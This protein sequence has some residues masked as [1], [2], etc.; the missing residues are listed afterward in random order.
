MK[1]I[2]NYVGP[3]AMG[4][5]MGVITPGMDIVNEVFEI[6]KSVHRD[7]LLNDGDII[8]ITESVVARAQDNYI[9]VNEVSDIIREALDLPKN[10]T[11]GVVFP[12]TSRNR[13]SMILE[14]IA[15]AVPEGKVIVQFSYP[16]DEVGNQVISPEFV[17]GLEKDLITLEDIDDEECIHP[18]TGVNYIKYYE[19]IIEDAGAESEII[20]CNDPKQILQYEPDGVIAADI[21]TRKKT[22]KAIKKEIDKCITLDEVCTE[23]EV[24]SKWGLLGSNMSS[25]DR[26]KLAPKNGDKVVNELQKRVKKE[27]GVEIE[28]IIYGDGAYKDP[29]SGIYE[30]ADPT[31]AVAATDGLN[32]FRRGVKYKYIADRYYHEE[33]KDPEEIE[34]ILEEKK[35]E[36]KSENSM[37]KE[38]TTPRRMEDLL[39][40]LADLVSGSADAGTP[41]VLVKNF[42]G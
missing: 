11:V 36:K 29:T 24:C 7:G 9:E 3:M 16:S 32:H 37:E 26:L 1:G 27:L 34:K 5:K 21:H 38:G 23:G 17:R 6:I 2:P 4:L 12:I 41:V 18:I 13:F 22:R 31:P 28:S 25:G 30:L 35:S 20:L 33:N 42:L 19:E 8:C 14:S 40:S 15:T 39:G 10:G